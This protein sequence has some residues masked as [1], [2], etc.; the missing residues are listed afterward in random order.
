M[1]MS[2]YSHFGTIHSEN[3]CCSPKLQKNTKT[4]YFKGS[5]SF[6]VIDVDTTKKLVTVLV[7]ISTY[8]SA[9]LQQFLR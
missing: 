8:V 7:V 2:I 6:K 5:R 4:L 3:V 1:S 9:Y